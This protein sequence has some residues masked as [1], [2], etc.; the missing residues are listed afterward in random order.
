MSDDRY[1]LGWF[2]AW[3]W[4]LNHRSPA[5][6]MAAPAVEAEMH[7]LG[8]TGEPKLLRLGSEV[9]DGSE[10]VGGGCSSGGGDA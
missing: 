8:C 5:L 10:A 3:Q 7:R 4:L 9:L 6:R 2:D 1:L